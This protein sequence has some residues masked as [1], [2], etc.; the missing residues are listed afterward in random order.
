[1]EQ[2]ELF[3]KVGKKCD[4]DSSNKY[5]EEILEH[6]LTVPDEYLKDTQYGEKWQEVQT[7]WRNVLKELCSDI[8]DTINVLKMAGRGNNYDYCINYC[9]SEKVVNKRCIEFKY[10]SSGLDKIPQFLQLYENC[11]FIKKSYAEFYY[12]N[13]LSKHIEYVPGLEILDKELYLKLIKGTKYNC[14]P[15]FSRLKDAEEDKASKSS[16]N[17]VVNNSIADYLNRYAKEIDLVN[18]QKR[19]SESQ[20]EKVFVM[21]KSGKFTTDKIFIGN[22]LEYKGIKNNNTIVVDDLE[23]K[24]EYHLLLRWKNHKGVLNPA[25]QISLHKGLTLA[26]KLVN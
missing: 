19:L 1:M 22:I 2:I 13:Y 6:I 4:N 23:Q 15:F 9:N 16:I 25:W 20:R 8:F 10:N 26:K 5:R 11:G 24:Q 18:L 7:G 14:N 17:K 12:E 3:Y 21:W